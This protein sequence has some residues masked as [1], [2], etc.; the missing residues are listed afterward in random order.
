MYLC[1]V[2]EA[3]CTGGLPSATSPIQPAFVVSAVALP[4]AA[5]RPLTTEFLKLKYQFFPGL[6]ASKL[7]FLDAV[8]VEIK[9]AEL[10]KDIAEGTREER[11]HAIG[12][13]DKTLDLLTRHGGRVFGRI[14]VKGIGEPFNGTAVYAYSIQDICATFQSLL[15]SVDEMGIVIAD[16]RNKPKDARVSH[17]IFTL[18]HRAAGDPLD[19]IVEMPIFGH[20][21]NHVGLQLADLLCSAF[22]FPMTMHVFCAGHVQNVHVRPGYAAIHTRYTPRLK[23]LQHRYYDPSK[24]RWRGGITVSDALA[25]RPSAILFK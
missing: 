2:D 25:H 5:V 22:L 13:L 10:R 15:V 23:A 7:Q 3:G 18:K 8:L 20:S 11:R 4:L 6:T 17:S 19:R 14:W 9:G 1:Y 12:F 24:N 21:D 16:A